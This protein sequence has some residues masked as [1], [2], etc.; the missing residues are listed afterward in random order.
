MAHTCFFSVEMPELEDFDDMRKAM[1]T[2]IE[3]GVTGI[4]NG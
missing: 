2:A 1:L 4:L 3:Y